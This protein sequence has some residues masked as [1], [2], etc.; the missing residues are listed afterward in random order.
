MIVIAL[1]LGIFCLHLCQLV[2]KIYEIIE[3]KLPKRRPTVRIRRNNNNN[4]RNRRIN[5]A[6]EQRR[7]FIVTHH[8]AQQSN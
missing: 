7:R 4:N 1:L 5:E 8:S 3:S 2:I 6:D